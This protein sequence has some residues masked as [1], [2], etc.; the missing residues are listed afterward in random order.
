MLLLKYSKTFAQ[1]DKWTISEFKPLTIYWESVKEPIY[2]RDYLEY[3]ITK[4]SW[5]F[6]RWKKKMGKKK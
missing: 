3:K 2:S 1:E 5:G 4:Q 6:Y